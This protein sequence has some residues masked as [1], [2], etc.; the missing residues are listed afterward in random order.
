MAR[1]LAVLLGVAILAVVMGSATTPRLFAQS[2]ENV[3]YS[4]C[5][6]SNC[7]DGYEPYAAGVIFD[8]AGNLY[9]TTAF[10]GQYQEG[11]VFELTPTSSGPWT[12]TVLHSFGAA[13][14]GASP[15][16]GLIFDAKG[17][18]YGTTQEGGKFGEGTVFEMSPTSKGTWN[19]KV[20]FSFN[21]KDGEAPNS[22]IIFDA[23]GNIYGTT[24]EGGGAGD[25]CTGLGC[26]VVYQLAKGAKGSW[27]EK[28]L[29]TFSNAGKDGWFPAA[30][31][32]MDSAGTLYGVTVHGGAD[33]YGMVFQVA[34]SNGKWTETILHSF[35]N[36]DGANPYGTLILDAS[37]NLY[38]TTYTTSTVFELVPGK[39]GGWT[40]KV[41]SNFN[42]GEDGIGPYAGLTFDPQG[43]LYGTTVAGG[44]SGDG[45]VFKLA[46]AKGGKWKDSTLFSFDGADGFEAF[47]GVTLDKSGN[48]YGTSAAGGANNLG[49]VY[50]VTP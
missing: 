18:L 38:G 11:V 28:V 21:G 39:N 13:G 4:F 10:G 16:A 17:N 7:A 47:G 42:F 29:H 23:S 31:V 33:N 43:N 49:A 37:G 45:L 41:L 1:R 30:G 27:S 15:L 36:T 44:Q 35:D 8:S 14:D 26:G 3:L 19:E 40:E 6:V 34:Q 22:G 20:L 50:E 9:G 2:S 25:G 46:R 24:Y 48:I 12:E 32:V 5:S